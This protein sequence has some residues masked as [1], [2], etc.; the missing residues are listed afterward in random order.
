MSDLGFIDAMPIN[1]ASNKHCIT[2]EVP[3]KAER[4]SGRVA[5][6]EFAVESMLFTFY[7]PFHFLSPRCNR[8]KEWNL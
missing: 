8:S 2:F 3:Q 7:Q 5:D 6:L 4:K 1:L